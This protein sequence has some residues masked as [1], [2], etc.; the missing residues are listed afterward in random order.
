MGILENCMLKFNI[1]KNVKNPGFQKISSKNVKILT[2]LKP[3]MLNF[4]IFGKY[5]NRTISGV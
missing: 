4:N 1:Y 2:F 5:K 3:K